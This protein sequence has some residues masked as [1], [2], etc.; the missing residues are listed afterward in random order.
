MRSSR[1]WHEDDAFWLAM[2]PLFFGTKQWA[3]ASQEAEQ[4]LALIGAGPGAAILDLGCGPG[5][6]SLEFAR[7]GCRV[8]GIDRTPRYLDEARRRAGAS[9]LGVEFILDDMRRFSRP[10]AFDGAVSLGTSFGYFKDPEDDRR[11][12][13]NLYRSLKH[14]GVLVVE[15][16][17]RETVARD[18]RPAERHEAGDGT[19]FLDER[20]ITRNGT[21]FEKKRRIV[22]DGGLRHGFHVSHRLYS[23]AGFAVVLTGCG[24]SSVE[25]YGD[26]AASPY[27]EKAER[28]VA[29]ARR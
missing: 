7:R 25:T 22:V 28:L 23:A 27:D 2:Y 11:V 24:F 26:L 13:L 17:G 10:G 12:L 20:S 16:L 4:A 21:W 8:T 9:G 18:F 14:E 1:A 3:A 15:M 6:H 19:V 5:R 29:V